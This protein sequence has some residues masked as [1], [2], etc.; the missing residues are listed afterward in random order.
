MRGELERD[1]LPFSSSVNPKNN[2]KKMSVV[3]LY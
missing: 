2:K 3:L 1:V